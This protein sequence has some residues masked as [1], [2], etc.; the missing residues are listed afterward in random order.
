MYYNLFMYH[1]RHIVHEVK[2]LWSYYNLYSSLQW[3]RL[4]RHLKYPLRHLVNVT[5]Q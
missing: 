2:G 5:M 1:V 4:R 3:V